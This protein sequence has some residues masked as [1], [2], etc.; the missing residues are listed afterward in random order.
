MPASPTLIGGGPIAAGPGGATGAEG[1]FPYAGVELLAAGKLR[2]DRGGNGGLTAVACLG[3]PRPTPSSI[4]RGAP[5]LSRQGDDKPAPSPAQGTPLGSLL[6]PQYRRPSP[7]STPR[8]PVA[9][10]EAWW[11]WSPA[12]GPGLA[13]RL[14]AGCRLAALAATLAAVTAA[15]LVT[16]GVGLW[17]WL[18]HLA[19]SAHR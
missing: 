8:F 18:G 13:G 15:G 2:L 9:D 11:E 5:P 17:I 7:A 12:P 6:G 14:W 19:S 1:T 16:A 10:D 3:S 4:P